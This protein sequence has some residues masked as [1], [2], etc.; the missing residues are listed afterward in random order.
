MNEIRGVFVFG[1]RFADQP[2]GTINFSF[3]KHGFNALFYVH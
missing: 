3:L 2:L 1:M